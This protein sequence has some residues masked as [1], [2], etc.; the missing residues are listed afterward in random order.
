MRIYRIRNDVLICFIVAYLVTWGAGSLTERVAAQMY[1]NYVES[2]RVADGEIGGKAGEE[3][4]RVQ[5]VED[6][7]SHDRF[8][9]V[10]DINMVRVLAGGY[11]GR[12]Y[13]R[14]FTAAFGGNGCCFLQF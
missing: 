14:Q 1:E 13:L 2:N 5:S 3:V 7:L 8:T 10:A 12:T 9:M 4:F 11:F 6:I